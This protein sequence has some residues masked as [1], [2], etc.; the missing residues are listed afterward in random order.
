MRRQL[1]PDAVRQ[2]FVDGGLPVGYYTG[3]D[4]RPALRRPVEGITC[5]TR[6]GGRL[7][8][9]RPGMRLRGVGCDTEVVVVSA[10]EP[11]IDVRCGEHPMARPSR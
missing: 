2:P 7:M 8:Q 4:S 6:E 1:R 11:P 9:V 3:D 10:A 5:S